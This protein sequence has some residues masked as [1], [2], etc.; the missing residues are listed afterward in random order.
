[1]GSTKNNPSPNGTIKQFKKFITLNIGLKCLL[2]Q[3]SHSHLPVVQQLEPGL[4]TYR[5]AVQAFKHQ[6]LELVTVCPHQQTS[7][8]ILHQLEVLDQAQG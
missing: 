7:C 1:M 2:E 8:I 3:E 4:V 5:R 6:S